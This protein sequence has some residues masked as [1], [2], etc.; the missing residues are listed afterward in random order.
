MH[1]LIGGIL[2]VAGTT[3]GAGMLALPISTGLAGFWPSM[4]L[5]VFCWGFMAFT[6]FLMLEVNLW[7]EDNT[8]LIT[9]ARRT[10]GR[11]GEIL[12]WATY[13]FLLYALTTAY[14][15]GSG[16]LVITIMHKLTGVVLPAYIGSIPLLLLFGFCVYR[17]TASVDYVNRILIVG[18]V[19]SFA[20][21]VVL[22]T[23]HVD[24]A[25]LRQVVKWPAVGIAISLVVTSFG[26]HII[27][28]TLIT[29]LKRDVK[30]LK[31][32]I[33]VGSLI[34]LAV[35]LIWELLILGIIP[36]EGLHGLAHG[37]E[38]GID[39][40]QLLSKRMDG[41]AIGMIAQLFS[42]FA[43]V[44]SFLGV[45]LSL[46]DFLSDGLKIKK[47]RAGRTVLYALTFLPPVVFTLAD[48]RIFF[49]ALEY[50]GAFGV[51][52]LLALLPAL[53]TW[54]GRYHHRFPS[55]F[56]VPGGKLSLIAA[57]MISVCIIGLEIFNQLEWG[58]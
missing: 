30:Q 24:P 58:S 3:I 35:Y 13:L 34:P 56:K 9:M 5:L 44:T 54:R 18:L 28:P 46:S 43:V 29:Y 31:L 50:A 4:L 6:A 14:I 57:I 1:K 51:V 22:L 49:T 25:L 17:G 42:F 2:L 26:Y 27:I 8:N 45:S 10:L 7:M 55:T 48:P 40:A 39:A 11:G 20:V 53:M 16:P 33:L 38:E 15:A 41:H 36:V 12:S 37:Y 52:V 47:T 32:V 23:P 21:L 19:I